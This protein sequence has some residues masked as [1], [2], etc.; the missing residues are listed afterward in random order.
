MV[1]KVGYIGL[2]RMGLLMASNAATAGFDQMVYDLRDEPL[3]ELAKLGAQVA[4]SAKEVG[5]HAEVVEMSVV[6]DEQVEEV[7]FGDDGVLAGAKP[8]TVIAIL[9]TIQPRTA[10]MMWEA[11]KEKGV[12][13]L[14]APVSGAQGGAR[15]RT[16]CYMVGGEAS[17]L[18]RCRP[19]FEAS[20]AHIIHTGPL[21]TG[22]AMKL[23]QQVIYCLTQLAAYE[24]M[25]L[26]G[27]AGVD[28]KAAQEVMHHALGGSEVTDNYQERYG[29]KGDPWRQ[30]FS[31]MLWSVSPA[32]ELGYDLG[33]PMPATALMQQLF[34]LVGQTADP[35]RRR[36]SRQGIA[37]RAAARR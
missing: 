34:P 23:T 16:L 20:G 19:V 4:R 7:V 8:G 26:A 32:I 15:G 25:S 22:S 30:Q 12:G 31:A 11:A 29:G 13:V 1:T 24:G 6:N 33:V 17:L 3:Q 5:A 28:I 35:A 9:S 27:K 2:G 37:Q 21:G 36:S 14:D 10:V 18:E